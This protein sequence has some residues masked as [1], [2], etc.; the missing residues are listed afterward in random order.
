MNEGFKK[1]QARTRRNEA[2]EAIAKTAEN[3]ITRWLL[4]SAVKWDE[5]VRTDLGCRVWPWLGL[6]HRLTD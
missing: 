3:P 6:W 5:W 1:I 2:I 4:L